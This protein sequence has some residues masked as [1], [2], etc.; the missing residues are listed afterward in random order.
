MKKKI[1]FII[2]ALILFSP[3]LMNCTTVIANENFENF[4]LTSNLI[5]NFQ[6]DKFNG[7]ELNGSSQCYG[8]KLKF[9]MLP[10]WEFKKENVQLRNKYQIG[11]KIYLYYQAALINRL[12]IY[13]NVKLSQATSKNLDQQ[14]T[15]FLAVHESKQK[16]FDLFGPSSN[17]YEYIICYHYD[18]GDDILTHNS[19]QNSFT[20]DLEMIFDI[21]DSPVPENLVDSQGNTH[22]KEFAYISISSVGVTD[23]NYGK[24]SNDMPT[25]TGIVPSEDKTRKLDKPKSESEEYAYKINP[26][27]IPNS[28]PT[29]AFGEAL[30]FQSIGSSMNPT[31]KDGEPIWSPEEEK[32]MTGARIKFNIGKIS[33]MVY[34]WTSQLQ[35]NYLRVKHK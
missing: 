15:K 5:R 26:T 30:Q 1:N 14:A 34:E 25:V 4:S 10:N 6:F 2:F 24:M 8:G 7:I 28:E 33:P 9:E 23:L 21:D 12:N 17:K 29:I 32:S 31:T 20:G 16:L 22:K 3:L 13:T 19:Q 18:F 11:D 27:L 35:Y